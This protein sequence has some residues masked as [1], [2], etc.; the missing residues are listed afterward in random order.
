MKKTMMTIGLVVL[1]AALYAQTV[2]ADLAGKTFYYKYQFT[3]NPNT[4]V[5][6]ISNVII[7]TGLSGDSTYITFTRNACYRSDSNGIQ[8]TANDGGGMGTYTYQ[9]EQNNMLVFH[10]NRADYWGNN[11]DQYLYFSKD[12]KRLN[13]THNWGGNSGIEVFEQSAPP[14]PQTGSTGPDRMW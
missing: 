10:L 1:A 8:I 7:L 9:G 12:Y 6:S 11:Y 5:R 4:E 14:A 3:V 13:Y 2:P